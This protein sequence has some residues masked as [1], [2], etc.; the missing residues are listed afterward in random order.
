MFLVD[1][2]LAGQVEWDCVWKVFVD[3]VLDPVGELLGKV[4]VV[5]EGD[6]EWFALPWNCE[7]AVVEDVFELVPDCR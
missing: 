1:W 5:E 6:S 3:G 7:V 2:F 4:C